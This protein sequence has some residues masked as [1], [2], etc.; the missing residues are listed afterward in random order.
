MLCVVNIYAADLSN[1]G[2]DVILIVDNSGSMGGRGIMA[3]RSDNHGRRT[4]VSNILDYFFYRVSSHA[5][6]E[7]KTYT[8]NL[9]TIY[10]DTSAEVERDWYTISYTGN[11]PKLRKYEIK[12]GKHTDYQKA[13]DLA[14]KQ[15]EK[16]YTGSGFNKDR[17]PAIIMLTDGAPQIASNYNLGRS[18]KFWQ[19]FGQK[20]ELM[21]KNYP[22]LRFFLVVFYNPNYKG[23]Y[24]DEYRAKWEALGAELLIIDKEMSNNQMFFNVETKI[25]NSLYG[26][27]ISSLDKDGNFYVPSMQDK[28]FVSVFYY[29]KNSSIRLT[30]PDNNTYVIGGGK[31]R[32][33]FAKTIIPDPVPGK[34]TVKP[35]KEG[36]FD[37]TFQPLSVSTN[38]IYPKSDRIFLRLEK[39][40]EFDM[41]LSKEYEQSTV[42]SWNIKAHIMIDENNDGTADFQ[43]ELSQTFDKDAKTIKFLSQKPYMPPPHVSVVHMKTVVQSKDG[44]VKNTGWLEHTVSD[45]KI[46]KIDMS[47]SYNKYQSGAIK[48]EALLHLTDNYPPHHKYKINEVLSD[49]SSLKLFI[50]CL[51]DNCTDD[52]KRINSNGYIGG[53]TFSSADEYTLK[54]SAKLK[55]ESG[56]SLK[57]ALMMKKGNLSMKIDADQNFSVNDDFLL[58]I[59]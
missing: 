14:D 41:L 31:D 20:F 51:D 53:Y 3:E 5:F 7:Q 52:N 44:D 15:Y 13:F 55:T 26:M 57:N 43:S 45:K 56:S 12:I 40:I 29:D 42:K 21:K 19:E 25:A 11:D 36:V 38:Y 33:L 35:Y 48:V 32:T 47:D 16:L 24:W 59:E 58:V 34:W 27:N 54:C 9:S 39:P 37:F 23:N 50:K 6:S 30:D 18:D 4:M 8:T 17:I 10:F 28:L 46:V 2:F 1:K 22:G 49:Y